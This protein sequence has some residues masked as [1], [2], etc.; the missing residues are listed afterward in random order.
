MR[1]L[2][3]VSQAVEPLLVRTPNRALV[4]LPS[5]KLIA[6]AV[7]E[8]P[9]RYVLDRSVT[10]FAASFAFFDTE[11]LLACLDLVRAPAQSLWLEW[12]DGDRAPVLHHAGFRAA[13]AERRRAG[14]LISSE[15]GG[16]SGSM[17]V[18]WVGDDG[19]PELSSI[20][21]DFDLDAPAFAQQSDDPRDSVFRAT[22]AHDG[23]LAGQAALATLFGHMRF[24]LR[25]EWAAYYASQRLSGAQAGEALTANCECVAAEFPFAVGFLLALAARNA[26]ALGAVSL[27]R[28]NR[29][30]GRC[31]KPDLLDYTEVSA[32]L[33]D[34]ASATPSAAGFTRAPSRQHFVCGHLVRRARQVFWRRSHLRGNPARGI[35]LGRNIR[36]RMVACQE[37]E[38]LARRA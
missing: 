23:E 4:E 12:D 13:A 9:V 6:S 32:L 22:L 11:R 27:E 33:G 24:R 5:P 1:L 16:R 8:T 25:P 3:Q 34:I 36:L 30:R 20:I 21:I 35:V 17:Q 18:V 29:A 15:P 14:L 31:G 19:A 2:D 7:R 28:L 38:R 10:E 26:V 37:P